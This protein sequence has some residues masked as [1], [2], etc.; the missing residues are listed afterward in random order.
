MTDASILN[1]MSCV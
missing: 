1:F